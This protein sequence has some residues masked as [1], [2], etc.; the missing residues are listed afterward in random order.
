VATTSTN[1]WGRL[2]AKDGRNMRTLAAAVQRSAQ[3]PHSMYQGFHELR[4]SSHRFTASRRGLNRLA[5]RM[6]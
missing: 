4:K 5:S 6:A 1:M 2:S 3:I